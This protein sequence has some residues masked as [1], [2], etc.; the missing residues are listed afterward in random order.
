MLFPYCRSWRASSPATSEASVRSSTSLGRGCWSPGR[1]GAGNC[2][3]RGTGRARPG[4]PPPPGGRCGT[5]WRC[6]RSR[7]RP[8]LGGERR[9][10]P[11][12]PD[13][14][15]RAGTRITM[16]SILAR[17]REGRGPCGGN[18]AV[19]GWVRPSRTSVPGLPAHRLPPARTYLRKRHVGSQASS[20][21]YDVD[22][23]CTGP[24]HHG[25]AQRGSPPGLAEFACGRDGGRFRDAECLDDL[26]RQS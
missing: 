12:R 26:V 14:P 7:C 2:R 17:H 3:D 18:S 5:P 13:G 20:G 11:L 10:R 24:L 15:S 6:R 22:A 19:A 25:V 9:T 8:R 4:R 23:V 21:R 1:G 16:P